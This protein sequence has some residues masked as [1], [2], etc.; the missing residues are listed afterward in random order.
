MR[1]HLKGLLYQDDMKP[2][3]LFLNIS[4]NRLILDMATKSIISQNFQHCLYY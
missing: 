4:V 2:I 1:K 3:Y